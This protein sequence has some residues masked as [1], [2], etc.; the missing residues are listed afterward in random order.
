MV[1]LFITIRNCAI[2]VVV[3]LIAL[4]LLAPA[5]HAQEGSP[6][7]RII[8]LSP[9]LVE[10]V[11]ALGLTEKLVGVSRFTQY[12]EAARKLAQVGGFLDPN[13]EGM[14]A[15]KPSVVLGLSEHSDLLEKLKRF[16][17]RTQSA[18]HRSVVGIIE[19]IK[20]IGELCQRS[21]E[22][23]QVIQK[24][25]SLL[26]AYRQ[27]LIG[28]KRL[29]TLV[30]IGGK[31]DALRFTNLYVSGRDGYYAD[32]LKIAGAENIFSGITRPFS[33]VSREAFIK[34]N[35]DVVFQVVTDANISASDKEAILEAWSDLPFLNAVKRKNIFLLTD[36][37]DVIPGPRFPETL[38]K[39]ALALEGAH[40]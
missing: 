26:S 13:L 9:S 24:L 2:R 22:A 20:K 40:R 23:S 27:K 14:L 18:D 30:L 6:C 1:D 21:G 25:E 28:K 11:A 3:I 16:G 12:P 36:Y 17:S 4:I 29:R 8:A 35:P 37:V 38:E 15:L 19:S 32:L 39:M 10:V 31:E 7:E 33:G 5:L 34:E